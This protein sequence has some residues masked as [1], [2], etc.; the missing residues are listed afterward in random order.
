MVGKKVKKSFAEYE[1][2]T[3]S[4]KY[5][6][7][8]WSDKNKLTPE[9][10]S[11]G[12]H[13]KYWFNCDVCGHE[14]EK[15]LK[16]VTGKD[17]WCSYCAHQNLCHE[18]DC[19]VCYNNSFASYSELT[20]KGN[21]KVDR[22][23][24]KNELTPRDLFLTDGK[25]YWFNCDVCGHEFESALAKVTFSGRWCPYCSS[26]KLCN[27][28]N[29]KVCYNKTLA[30]YEEVTSKGN[31]K[32]DCWS[33]KNKLKPI[34]VFLCS[35]RKYWFNCDVC[36]H[37]FESAAAKVSFSGRWCPYCPNKKLCDK[38]DC[39]DCY[40]KSF[41]SYDGK[42]P[43][44]KKKVDL[45]SSKN[46]NKPRDVFIGSDKK[47]LFDCDVCGHEFESLIKS[48]KNGHWCPNCKNKTEL[49]LLNWLKNCDLIISIEKEYSPDWC[50]T[51]YFKFNVNKGC[52]D[53]GKYQY[54]FDFLV[55][56]RGK[57]N[58]IIE[59][60]GQQHFEQVSNWKSPFC[61]QI[62]DKYKEMKAKQKNI[63]VIRILQQDVWLDK[64]NWQKKLEDK[65]KTY[66]EV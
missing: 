5:K 40:N 3:S 35:M 64:N 55:T 41:A 28:S 38:K 2:K 19:Q 63:Q 48:I 22:W 36:G 13:K 4:G 31:K 1:G 61:Q 57:K 44:G 18:E 56:I 66:M 49:K 15:I 32:I 6:R 59:L 37:E 20:S 42:T 9:E 11:Y 30:S 54:R 14:F 46:E 33:D 65:I 51:K 26:K 7:D 53:K 29:C 10:V 34:N 17:S 12:T 45:W 8:C 62:R 58:I 50:S 21:K 39:Q 24:N 47:F 16:D 43:S 23:S 52:I 27:D 25:K 60:D